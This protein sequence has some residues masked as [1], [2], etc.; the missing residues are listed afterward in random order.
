MT[1]SSQTSECRCQDMR[2]GA[3]DGPSSTLALVTA[4]VVEDDDI[5]WRPCKHEQLLDI[6]RE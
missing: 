4:D 6:S 2:A 1:A 5:T 3:A